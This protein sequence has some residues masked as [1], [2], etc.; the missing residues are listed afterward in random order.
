MIFI[1]ND[2][3]KM[4][5]NQARTITLHGFGLVKKIKLGEH[6]MASGFVD[7]TKNYIIEIINLGIRDIGEEYEVFNTGGQDQKLPD[8]SVQER[9]QDIQEERIF[10]IFRKSKKTNRSD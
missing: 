1:K 3:I 7:G 10:P 4:K 2:H 9:T 6:I 8:A 5:I